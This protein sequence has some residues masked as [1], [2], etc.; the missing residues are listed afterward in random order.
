MSPA[1]EAR[2]E[3][4]QGSQLHWKSWDDEFVVFDE[5]SGDTHLLDPLAAE[6]L[7]TLEEA[8]GDV[9]SLIARVASRLGIERAPEIERHIRA[10][11]QRFHE[12][13][14]AEPAR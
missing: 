13:G 12:A 14:L 1:S 4:A 8:P 5:G 10:T 3:L 6:V 2:W 11:I 7:K 9:P